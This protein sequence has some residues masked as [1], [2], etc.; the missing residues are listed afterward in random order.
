[1]VKIGL[2]GLGGMGKVHLKNYSYIKDCQVTALCDLSTDAVQV[3]KGHGISLY[4]SV[5]DMLADADIDA[6]DICTP[7]FMHAE[8]IELSLLANKHV[9]CEKP[10]CLHQKQ[11]EQLI[12]LTREKKCFLMIGQV[13]QYALQ[14]QIL[15]QCIFSGRYGKVLDASF[16]RCGEAPGWSTGNWMLDKT[17]SG[18]IPFDLH[19]HDL[20]LIVSLFPNPELR[21]VHSCQGR[22][23]LYPEYYRFLYQCGDIQVQ[24]EAAWYHARVPFAASWKVYFENALLES[25]PDGSVTAYPFDAPPYHFELTEPV[26][27]NSD[28]NLPATGMFYRELSDF[29]NRVQQGEIGCARHKE[30]MQVLEILENM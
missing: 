10:F 14:T 16:T 26:S 22:G 15:R 30:I 25:L 29:I 13:L 17:R 5:S 27:V 28:I 23:S 4:S 3:S 24:A 20:D 9:L 1:M 19:I 7:T 21:M 11:A 12:H 6:V 18:L 2:I 8:H